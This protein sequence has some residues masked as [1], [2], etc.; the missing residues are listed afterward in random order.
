MN[1]FLEQFEQLANL[2]VR[3][4]PPEFDRKLHERLNRSLVV[5]HLLDLATGAVPHALAEFARAVIGLVEF[6]MTGRFGEEKPRSPL[7]PEES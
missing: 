1:D 6:S 3:Q 7:P 5:Q 2:E 4:P